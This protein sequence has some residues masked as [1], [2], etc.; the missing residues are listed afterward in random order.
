[1]GKVLPASICIYQR[2]GAAQICFV[3]IFIQR[4]VRKNVKG[5]EE[6]KN[7]KDESEKERGEANQAIDHIH[8]SVVLFPISVFFPYHIYADIFPF[9]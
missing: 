2:T 4:W 1:M 9:S 6:R 5:C 3:H 7:R 8:P